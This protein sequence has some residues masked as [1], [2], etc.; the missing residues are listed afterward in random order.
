MGTVEEAAARIQP[1]AAPDCTPRSG[2][3]RLR[4]LGLPA[5]PLPKGPRLRGAS[6]A[7]SMARRTP[8]PSPTR[9]TL[10]RLHG[11]APL[12]QNADR[13]PLPTEARGGTSGPGRRERVECD[14]E[15]GGE[16]RR[17]STPRSGACPRRAGPPPR[18]IRRLR[19]QPIAPA[20][21]LI[22]ESLTTA[23]SCSRALSCELDT[24]GLFSWGGG[25]GK[26]GMM[27]HRFRCGGPSA[28]QLPS[29]PAWKA[30][31]RHHQC[32][33]QGNLG[34]QLTLRPTRRCTRGPC[35]EST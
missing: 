16:K 35:P 28:S 23:M 32:N 27:E 26:P 19:P 12:P 4:Q 34:V 33:R 18:T 6:Q 13:R 8:D 9:R 3:R 30:M 17:G 11:L 14:G 21:H 20:A 7:V 24:R 5:A 2:A 10:G 29:E 22:W 25:G 15:G 1:T 31:C